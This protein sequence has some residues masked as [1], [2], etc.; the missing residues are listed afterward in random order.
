MDDIFQIKLAPANEIQL[1]VH[2]IDVIS[3]IAFREDG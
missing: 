2:S 3:S 1:K